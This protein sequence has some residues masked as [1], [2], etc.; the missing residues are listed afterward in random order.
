MSQLAGQACSG[1]AQGGCCA[2]AGEVPGAGSVRAAG[3]GSRRRVSGRAGARRHPLRFPPRQKAPV[4]R[5]WGPRA[6]PSGF[7]PTPPSAGLH[8]G[9]ADANPICQAARP[10]APGFLLARI[11]LGPP[12]TGGDPGARHETRL[13]K[14]G[15]EQGLWRL[16]AVAASHPLAARSQSSGS[17]CVLPLPARTCSQ[18]LRCVTLS[19]SSR[20]PPAT[21]SEPSA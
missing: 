8:P 17:V 12:A 9:D 5:A 4:A 11:R 14:G 13:F 1:R 10:A 3:L 15:K 2:P 16:M 7:L 21:A 20:L 19:K 18:A 6:K